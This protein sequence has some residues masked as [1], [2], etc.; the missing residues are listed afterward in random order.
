MRI[1]TTCREAVKEVERDLWEMGIEVRTY[2]MQDKV[3]EGNEDYFTK[4]LSPYV[5]MI[6]NPLGDIDEFIKYIYPDKHERILDW[7]VAEFRERISTKMINPGEAWVLRS[8]IWKEFMH[9]G[10]FAYTYN[11]R[12]RVQLER[13]INE[14]RTKPGTR[15][16]IIEVHNNF[17]DINHLGG[18]GRVPCSM[19]YQLV[20]REGKLDMMYIMRS[21]DYLTHFCN[22][23]WLAIKLQQH[24]ANELAIPMGKY[25]FFTG[26]LHAYYKDMKERKIF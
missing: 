25:T 7:C 5:F 10:A 15:Q 13:I 4:E 1:Y 19:H 22:D 12:I 16:A 18:G 14:L 23:N 21:S 6:T 2:S 9:D 26:S 20:I 8:G 24:V 11:H 17:I 3:V